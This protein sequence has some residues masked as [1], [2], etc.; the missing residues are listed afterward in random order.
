MPGPALPSEPVS[1]L[2]RLRRRPATTALVAWTFFVWTARIRNIW[3]DDDMSTSAQVGATALALSFTALAVAAL[4]TVLRPGRG[5]GATLA[6]DL[7]AGWT[8]AVWA[9]RVPMIATNDHEAAFVVVHVA[10]AVLSVALAALAARE[11]RRA[12]RPAGAPGAAP[13][14]T[15]TA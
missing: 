4:V 8:V 14:A 7:L 13:V 6:V 15:T 5:R 11:A 2:A 3:G 12:A 9:V 10:L 1:A